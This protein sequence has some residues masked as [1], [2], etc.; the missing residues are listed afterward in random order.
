M[1]SD[2]AIKVTNLNKIYPIYDRPVDIV[3]EL[4]FRKKKHREYHALKDISFEVKKGEVVGVIGRNGAGK[5]TLLKILAGTL[6]K[7]SGEI[8]INGKISAILELGTGFNPEYTGRENI[9]LG[10]IATGI[11]RE[12]IDSKVE[13]IIDFSELR[14]VIDQPFKTYSSG[15][16]A[17]LTFSVAISVDPDIFIIDEAL[18]A[19]DAYFISKSITK[20]LEICNKDNVTVFFV[21]HS[22][23]LIRRLCSRALYID[24]GILFENGNVDEVTFNY[25]ALIFK[26]ISNMNKSKSDN[27]GIKIES[28][29][30]LFND[31][32]IFNIYN[33]ESYSF[34]QHDELRI[35]I[36]L[37]IK[38][39]MINPA[40]WVKI[41]RT[42]GVFVTSWLSHE[43]IRYDLGVLEES[44]SKLISVF[45]PDIQLGDG[46]F[47]L[48]VGI[49]PEKEKEQ[50]AYYND[51]ICLWE[52]ARYFNIQRRNRPLSTIFDQTMFIK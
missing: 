48:S 12:E 24:N 33:E 32:K 45:I 8:E 42:D 51:P 10:G 35:E 49:F 7:T 17:R 13:D 28:E 26:E 3:K 30:C 44:Q 23:D 37:N 34:Y 11:S 41:I 19:G 15:M 47:I 46:K 18:A 39:K 14:D 21:S 29:K 52:Q 38:I 31:I 6:S 16:Q 2:I 1:N 22:T 9:Y 43:P 36:D 20:I 5:S 27:N 50:T 25:E 4:L 40:I